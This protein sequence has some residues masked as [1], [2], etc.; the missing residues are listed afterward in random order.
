VDIIYD[1]NLSDAHYAPKYYVFVFGVNM[2]FFSKY[3]FDWVWYNGY[4][5]KLSSNVE[6][7]ASPRAYLNTCSCLFKLGPDGIP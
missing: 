7:S 2:E 5:F 6:V 1:D 4:K 3:L